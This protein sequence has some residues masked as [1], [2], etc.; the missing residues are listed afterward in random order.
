[1][2]W[3]VWCGYIRSVC[4]SICCVC[5]RMGARIVGASQHTQA[6]HH[7]QQRQQ[8]RQLIELV[9]L[10]DAAAALRP[11]AGSVAASWRWAFFHTPR[12]PA[13]SR[14]V[15]A[16]R[17]PDETLKTPTAMDERTTVVATRVAAHRPRQQ[18]SP[19][20]ARLRLTTLRPPDLLLL[21]GQSDFPICLPSHP[22]QEL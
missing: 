5:L 6:L 19:S 9:C 8:H 17:K 1:M 12:P 22:P 3:R 11:R 16:T 21:Q 14:L 18:A 2:A 20:R 4:G 15:D 7:Q 13:R 10:R